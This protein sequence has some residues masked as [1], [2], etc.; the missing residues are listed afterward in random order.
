LD[1]IV[2]SPNLAQVIMHGP[3]DKT[4]MACV[5]ELLKKYA[6]VHDQ[7][8]DEDEDEDDPSFAIS[9]GIPPSRTVAGADMKHHISKLRLVAVGR[10]RDYFLLKIAELRR[11]KTNV[12]M[13]QL[14]SLLKYVDL[15]DFLADASPECYG[16]IKRVYVESM[17]HTLVAL[18]RTYAAQLQRLDAVVATRSDLIAID[19]ATLRNAFSTKVNLQKRGDIFFLGSRAAILDTVTNTSSSN[20]A[21]K[22]TNTNAN[23]DM[24]A[25]RSAGPILAHVAL[26]E[27][28]RYPYEEIFR[29]IMMHL[30]DAATNEYV[31]VRLFFKEHGQEAFGE[32]FGRTLSLVLEQLEN[33]LFNCHDCLGI[34]LMIKVTHAQKRLMKS[35]SVPALDGF[36]DRVTHLLWPRLKMCM[37]AQLRSIKS[38]TATS[39]GGVDLHAHYVS[40]RYAEFTCSILLILQANNKEH[41]QHQPNQPNQHQH[42]HQHNPNTKDPHSSSKRSASSRKLVGTPGGG[43]N[44]VGIITPS[45]SFVTPGGYSASERDDDGNASIVSNQSGHSGSLFQSNRMHSSASSLGAGGRFSVASGVSHRTSAGDMLMNDLS[46]MLNEMVALLEKLADT[47]STNKKKI[48]FLINNLDQIICIF[49]ERRVSSGRELNTFVDLLMKQRELFVEE[50][51][52]QNF[53]KMIAFVQQTEAHLARTMGGA[54]SS[55]NNRG[56][57]SGTMSAG[58]NPSV[59][60]NLV[61]EFAANWKRGIDQINRNVLSYFSNFRNGMEILKQVLTQLLLYYTRFQDIIRRVWRSKIP[62]FCKDLVSTTAILAEIKKYA[63]SI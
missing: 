58:V 52:L 22:S 62:P 56:D 5:A 39:L 45:S 11:P 15:M 41:H 25:T 63:L 51:L 2:I 29:S 21:T 37:D 48:V 19:D 17:S 1:R 60:Q 42:Q 28:Q 10:V 43:A 53:S 46:I 34:L 7:K 3:V 55:R 36:L 6:Y 31:F 16:Q 13:I 61:S 57:A 18:F 49:Q 47:H 8:Y 20:Q 12:R 50:E 44:S 27:G 54:N 14:N 30:M 9:G 33:Y 26:A 35:R 4:Y 59:V 32:M 40:R 23:S 38:A 24:A